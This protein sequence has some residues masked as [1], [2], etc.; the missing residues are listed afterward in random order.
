MECAFSTLRAISSSL[1]VNI[2]TNCAYLSAPSIC[3]FASAL[4]MRVVPSTSSSSGSVTPGCARSSGW[5]SASSS[6]KG[7]SSDVAEGGLAATTA[8]SSGTGA[9]D[10]PGVALLPEGTWMMPL[11]LL[12]A[13]SANVRSLAPN[14]RCLSHACCAWRK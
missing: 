6:R 4:T 11:V 13:L 8:A 7:C 10:D 3:A 14:S 5:L 1:C 2:A 12:S 9:D